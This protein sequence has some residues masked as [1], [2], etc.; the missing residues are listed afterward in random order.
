MKNKKQLGEPSRKKRAYCD[1][2]IEDGLEKRN[3]KHKYTMSVYTVMTKSKRLLIFDTF[4][5]IDL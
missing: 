4:L 2:W 5:K 3:A 1:V